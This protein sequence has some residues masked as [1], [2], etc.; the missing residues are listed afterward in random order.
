M[1]IKLRKKSAQS[2]GQEERDANSNINCSVR[3]TETEENVVTI[4][5]LL[6]AFVESQ[7]EAEEDRAR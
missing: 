6:F 4:G 7:G 5:I 2:I 1:L 3:A